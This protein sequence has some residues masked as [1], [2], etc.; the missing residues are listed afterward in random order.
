[1]KTQTS[2]TL[3]AGT[4]GISLLILAL[5]IVSLSYVTLL[6][7][8][9]AI[10]HEHHNTKVDLLHE[11]SRVVRERSLRMYAMYFK[12]DPWFRDQEFLRFNALAVEF[13]RLRDRLL[14]MGL[15]PGEREALTRALEMIRTTQPLQEEIVTRLSGRQAEGI[16]QMIQ[17]DLPLENQL[18]T[19]FDELVGLVRAETRLAV[20]EAGR[21]VRNAFWL[22]SGVT[23]AVLGLTLWTMFSVR[24]RILSVENSLFEEKEL[25]ELTLQNITDGV[26][27][28]DAVG[29]VLSMNPVAMQ[30]T[31]W[32]E[33]QALGQPLEKIYPLR[34]ADSDTLL[35]RP[36]ILDE[37]LGTVSR[38]SRYLCLGHRN[39]GQVLIEEAIAPIHAPDGRLA[40]VAYIFRDVT[41]QKRESDRI[42]WQAAH[43]PLTRVLNRNG[44]DQVLER[45]L[46]Q[47]RRTHIGH[48]LV[49]I[50]LDDFKPI[51]DRF[52]HALGDELL[53]SLCRTIESC[54]R[55]GDHLARLGGDEFAV[56]LRNCGL[57]QA[58]EIAEEIRLRI[59]ELRLQADDDKLIGVGV[60]IGIAPMEADSGDGWRA[61][62]AADQACYLAKRD[63][64]NRVRL[65]A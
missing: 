59:E 8:K 60:S 46:G 27:K 24:R 25:E 17:E 13:I 22:L 41:W 10:I 42:A 23:L 16:E 1:M 33:S 48:C 58:R 18:L 19:V 9:V 12:D 45:A 21:D 64:K 43:D 55:M 36:A 3:M 38:L 11:M 26:I 34:Q 35:E 32:S 37:A 62:K 52:G 61:V 50:D 49:Y 28:T 20:A 7:D 29:R 56:L 44:F 6:R 63:G 31:G 30:L 14:A 5:A 65:S 47:A 15:T 57:E 51:N 40:Q 54:M 39:G 4:I 53:I 2:T